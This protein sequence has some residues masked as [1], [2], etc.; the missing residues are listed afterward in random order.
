MLINQ[1]WQMHNILNFMLIT[2][3]NIK[4]WAKHQFSGKNVD[5]SSLEK[6]TFLMLI[7]SL[8]Q[9]VIPHNDLYLVCMESKGNLLT[10]QLAQKGNFYVDYLT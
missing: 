10:T 5:Y 8:E 9:T 4:D 7:T 3:L 1:R 6:N 2:S